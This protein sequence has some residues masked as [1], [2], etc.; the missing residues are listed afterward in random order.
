MVTI[1]Q[2]ERYGHLTSALL[3]LCGTRILQVIENQTIREYLNIQQGVAT[4]YYLTENM[5]HLRHLLHLFWDN[6]K[7]LLI[8][9]EAPYIC[10]EAP[11]ICIEAPLICIEAP[12]ISMEPPQGANPRVLIVCLCPNNRAPILKQLC[13]YTQKLQVDFVEGRDRGVIGAR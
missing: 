7:A 5:L 8:C 1:Y 10:I 13:A 4:D 9:I 2:C 3:M 12:Y 6:L 11:Y